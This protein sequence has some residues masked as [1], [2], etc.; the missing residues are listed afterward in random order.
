MS[1]MDGDMELAV[2]NLR[3]AG[4]ASAT[5]KEGRATNEGLIGYTETA[6]TI[7]LV[8]VNSETDFVAKNENFHAFVGNIATEVANSSPESIE[9][10][11]K[12]TYS[13]DSNLSIEEYRATNVQ[14]L[15]ENLVIKNVFAMKKN[16]NHSYGIYSHMNGKIVVVVECSEAGREDVAR[17]VAMHVAAEAP[18]YL[19]A[20]DVPA[21][22]VEKEK[23][24]ARSQIQGKP[25]NIIDKIVDGKVRSF[26]DQFCLNNQKYIKDS[27]VSVEK[28][29]QNLSK[30]L[31][32]THFVRWQV[33]G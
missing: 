14:L 24:I 29:L 25:E 18:E 32:V 8:E 30:D 7:S 4:M 3:K 21:S 11:L 16:P 26:Y 28:F 19:N 2:E 33:G 6:D 15:G 5:K 13:Q 31:K 9:T 1:G 23:E 22:V 10:F 27:S 20:T 12:Q 17:D